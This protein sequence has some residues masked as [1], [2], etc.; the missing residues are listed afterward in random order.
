MLLQPLAK[1]VM[2]V[3]SWLGF[4]NIDITENF[5]FFGAFLWS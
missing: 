3:S 1:T 4:S 2:F 5:Q